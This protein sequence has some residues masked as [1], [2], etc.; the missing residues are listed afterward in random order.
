MRSEDSETTHL[1]GSG[2]VMRHNNACVRHVLTASSNVY[3]NLG[4][5]CVKNLPLNE[6]KHPFAFGW[7]AE[8]QPE[9]IEQAKK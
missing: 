5:V 4:L 3:L 6:K 9:Q 1:L 8:Q 7:A 2:P